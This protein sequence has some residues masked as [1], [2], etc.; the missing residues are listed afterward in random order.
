MRDAEFD[1]MQDLKH[2]PCQLCTDD[3][4]SLSPCMEIVYNTLA[5]CRLVV[6]TAR[7]TARCWGAANLAEIRRDGSANGLGLDP[8]SEDR[9]RICDSRAMKPSTLAT[10]CERSFRAY[11]V[12]IHAVYIANR[13]G[14]WGRR[15]GIKGSRNPPWRVA[16]FLLPDRFPP[17]TNRSNAVLLHMNATRRP[18]CA[19]RIP[20]DNPSRCNGAIVKK[21]SKITKRTQISPFSTPKTRVRKKNEP[22]TQPATDKEV[23][24]ARAENHTRSAWTGR[25]KTDVPST[26]AE[27]VDPPGL[28]ADG[29]KSLW[30]MAHGLRLTA[31]SAAHDPCG[32]IR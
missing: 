24:L 12:A 14:N 16:F 17:T 4:A 22:K 23:A 9:T 30:L 25:P 6:D 31:L 5:K 15:R 11:C 21:K 19:H 7:M 18:R 13:V 26:T 27:A 3:F 1:V 10:R 29:C 8:S 28:Y 32:P 20:R 2:E